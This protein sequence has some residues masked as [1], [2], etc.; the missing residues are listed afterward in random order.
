M[1]W[2]TASSE[3]LLKVIW[4]HLILGFKNDNNNPEF[5]YIRQFKYT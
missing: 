5:Y 4:E 1:L 3:T 2:I